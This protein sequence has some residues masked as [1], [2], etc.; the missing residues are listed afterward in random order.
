MGKGGVFINTIIIRDVEAGDIPSIKAI[1]GAT[2]DWL[3]II[4]CKATL[5]AALGIY[6]N[7]VLHDSTFGRVAVLNDKIVGVIFGSVDEAEL[8]YKMLIE[9]STIHA[10]TLLGSSD[11]DRKNIYEYLAKTMM[12]YKQLINGLEDNYDGTLDFLVLAKEAQ[13]LGLGKNLWRELKAYFKENNAE[14]IYLYS[15]TKCN[16][17][18]HERQGFIKRCEQEVVYNLT[19]EAVR[20]NHFLYDLQLN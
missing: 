13:G 19:E 10:L 3:D 1:I 2:W 16:F 17:G 5:D 4:E 18:F 11:A 15:D 12:V 7:Q 20:I 6:L 9:N 14:S 8:K